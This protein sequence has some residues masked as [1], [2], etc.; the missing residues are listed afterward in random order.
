[1]ATQSTAVI[2]ACG[3][4]SR[5]PET[6]CPAANCQRESRGGADRVND[7]ELADQRIESRES[8]LPDPVDELFARPPFLQS[9]C[10]TRPFGST[11]APTPIVRRV[12]P[13]TEERWRASVLPL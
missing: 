3:L 1:M 4:L 12:Q 5:N 9:P 10:A 11:H 7:S 6:V 13:V 8:R 2:D